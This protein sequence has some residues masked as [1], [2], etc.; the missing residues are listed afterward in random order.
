[1]TMESAVMGGGSAAATPNLRRVLGLDAATCLVM[2]MLLVAGAAPLASLLAL[3]QTLL[4]WAGIVLFPCAALMAG[5]AA[6]PRPLLVWLVVLGN[7]AWVIGSLGALTLR[8][9]PL[10][11]VFV[12]VQAAVVVGLLVLE[13]R[14]LASLEPGTR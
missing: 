3:P 1:M 4:F 14:G 6:R 8:P 2:G 10:G 7:A 11:I 13:R 9:N 5:A 12:L